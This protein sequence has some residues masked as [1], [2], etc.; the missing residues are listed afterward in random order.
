MRFIKPFQKLD[1]LA[2]KI[3]EDEKREHARREDL[4]LR[5]VKSKNNNLKL[6]SLKSKG[7]NFC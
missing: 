7:D 4:I 2:T 6:F 5:L 3:S 1:T